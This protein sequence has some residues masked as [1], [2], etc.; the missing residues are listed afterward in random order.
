MKCYRHVFV[1]P[2]LNNIKITFRRSVR[3]KKRQPEGWR[4]V[5]TKYAVDGD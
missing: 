1:I 5:K 2:Q 3:I 4:L